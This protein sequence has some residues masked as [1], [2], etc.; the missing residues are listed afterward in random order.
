MHYAHPLKGHLPFAIRK[1]LVA[2]ASA[3]AAKARKAMDDHRP[4][5]LMV[6]SG[7][8]RIPTCCNI[9]KYIRSRQK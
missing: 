3:H 2:P 7:S 5:S 4:E 6:K 1:S 8:M 9:K